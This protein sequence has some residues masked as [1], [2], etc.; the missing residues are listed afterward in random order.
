MTSSTSTDSDATAPAAAAP[1]HVASAALQRFAALAASAGVDVD[2]SEFPQGTR[3][4]AD[5]A[6]AVGCEVAAIVKSLVFMADDRAVLVLT[7]GANRVDEHRLATELDAHHVRKAT[8][9]EARAATGYAIGG[10]PPFCH[11]G[12]GVSAVLMDPDLLDHEQVWAAAGTAS[13]VFP[14]PPVRLLEA[15]GARTAAFTLSDPA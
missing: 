4:A 2:A 6:A 14:L 1:D 7:S 10:T 11:T 3:T 15:A 5:A 8:A 13:A 12:D 9:D